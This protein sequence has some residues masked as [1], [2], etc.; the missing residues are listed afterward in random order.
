MRTQRA[1]F[2]LL[3]VAWAGF[4]SGRVQAEEAA[5]QADQQVDPQVF[6]GTWNDERRRFWFAVDE[7]V[8]NEVRAAHF[9]LASFKEGRVD[10]DTL[11]LTSRSCVP[12]IGCY[13]YT[14]VGKLIGPARMDMHGYSDKCVF[15]E[16]CREKGVVVNFVL[17][18]AP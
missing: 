9:R 4:D 16:E 5:S 8:G 3:V 13:E 10:G 15:A 1:I 6:V 18:R 7:I 17:V 11:T 14:H 12:I 2:A